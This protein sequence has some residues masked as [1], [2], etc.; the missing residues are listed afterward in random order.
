[1]YFNNFKLDEL[2]TELANSWLEINLSNLG[3]NIDF[4]KSL[5]PDKTKMMAV[6]K[7]E[8]YGHGSV[9]VA[10][11]AKEKKVDYLGVATIAEG[12]I[13]RNEGI[14][15][16]VLVLGSVFPEQIHIALKYGIEI[17]LASE[18]NIRNTEMVAASLGL[19]AGVH[20]KIDTG[21]GR[22]GILPD[23][24]NSA[25]EL[26][27]KS[28]NLE[29]KGVFTHFAES[30]NPDF[31]FTRQQIK[32]FL[33]CIEEIKTAGFNNFII[34]AA[35]SSATLIHPESHFDM[36]RT[37]LAM[38]G[39]PDPET[40]G[41]EPVM[42]LK[43]RIIN[44]KEIPAGSSLG[45]GRSFIT[46]RDS[47]I[48]IIPIGYADGF[49]RVLSNKQEVLIGEKRCMVV[50]NISMDQCLVDLTDLQKVNIGDEV[51][52]LGKA[53]KEHITAKDWAAKSYRIPYEVLCGF[54]NRLPRIY[55]K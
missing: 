25:V 3:N 34:H 14:K 41:L 46:K 32:T 11:K 4:L 51:I 1:L 38:Y 26:L 24:L 16:P 45:Y 17:T 28:D 33:K 5:L 23:K 30:E 15:L 22:V 54:G 39:I 52:L 9:E 7:A 2:E 27:K 18:E 37:G 55:I 47:L 13:L 35:N 20:L 48:G 49:P 42:S 53:G 40:V 50:G 31:N 6:V 10:L 29:I 36:V 8:A 19:K 43:S 44:L 12:K 21:M